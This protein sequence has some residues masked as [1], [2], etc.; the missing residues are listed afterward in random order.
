[1]MKVSTKLLL[2]GLT[3]MFAL[4]AFAK[5]PR[6]AVEWLFSLERHKEVAPVVNDTYAE[7]CGSCHFAYPPGLLPSGS[8]GKLLNERA[9]QDHFGENAE[10]DADVLKE[11]QE[12]ALEHSAEKSWY[13]RSRK[14][15]YATQGKEEPL[16]ITDVSYIRRKHH[17]IP[18]KMITGNPDVESQSN[19]SACHT[20]ADK[21]IFDSDTVDIPNYGAFED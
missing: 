19:C 16:R 18:K 10:L 13:K 11:V 2:A 8:W 20:Q 9:L 14:I 7:E 4:S 15:T 12:Y 5:E 1:M 21:G 3:G 6:S 17:E